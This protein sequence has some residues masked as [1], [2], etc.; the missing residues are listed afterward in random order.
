MESDIIPLDT[1]DIMKIMDDLR[2]SWGLNI[3]KRT[4]EIEVS[5][6]R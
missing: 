2:S 6:D 1:L 3:L 4:I 5:Y